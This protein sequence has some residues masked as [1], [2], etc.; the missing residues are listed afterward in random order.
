MTGQVK[1]GDTAMGR[2]ITRAWRALTAPRASQFPAKAN[3]LLGMNDI[4]PPGSCARNWRPPDFS[5]LFAPETPDADEK[6]GRAR[7]DQPP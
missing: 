2:L 7:T 5:D 6:R 3:G 1:S 4:H